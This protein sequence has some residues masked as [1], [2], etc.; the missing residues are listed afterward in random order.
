MLRK[1]AGPCLRVGVDLVAVALPE[2]TADAISRN[3]RLHCPFAF[4]DDVGIADVE[5][6]PQAKDLPPVLG[7]RSIAEVQAE[8]MQSGPSWSKS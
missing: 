5:R 6:D 8:E 1:Q 4:A 2:L 7:Y 3:D